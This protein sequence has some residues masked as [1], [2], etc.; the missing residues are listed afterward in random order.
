MANRCAVSRLRKLAALFLVALWLPATLHC[1]MEAAE[2]H[3]LTH[4][5][6]SA[7][8]D[9]CPNQHDDHHALKDAPITASTS[10]LKVPP[11]SNSLSFVL[12]ALVDADH[13]SAAPAL[14]P[15]RRE[16]PLELKVAWQFSTRAAPPSQAP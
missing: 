15:T 13:Y 10:S 5:D 8:T 1:Q 9:H 2:V 7:S 12:F 16:P 11:P 3:F 4:D 14:S 6:H